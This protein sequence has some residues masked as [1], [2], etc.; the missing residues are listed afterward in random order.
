MQANGI[1]RYRHHLHEIVIQRAVAHAVPRAGSSR[2]A[3]FHTL[4]DSFAIH[5]RERG[6]AIRTVQELLGHRDASTQIY[7]H[8]LNRGPSAVISPLDVLT[9]PGLSRTR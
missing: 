2:R 4:R 1:L 5:L 8:V 9:P 3:S 7:T 6:H